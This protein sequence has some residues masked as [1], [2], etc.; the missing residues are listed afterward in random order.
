MAKEEIEKLKEKVEKDPLSK[1]FVPLA[2]EYRKN[3]MYDEAISVLLKGLENQPNYMTARVALGKIYLEKKMLKEAKEEFKKVVTAIPDNLFALKKIADIS[4]ELGE[5]SDAID[6][7]SKI[8]KLNPLDEEAK[9]SLEALKSKK[10]EERIPEPPASK[11]LELTKTEAKTPTVTEPLKEEPEHFELEGFMP[12]SQTSYS[13]EEFEKF[14]N[15]FTS[16]ANTEETSKMPDISLTD[17]A[18]EEPIDQLEEIQELQEIPEEDFFI[19][20]PELESG[21]PE[22]TAPSFTSSQVESILP[23][24]QTISKSS[25]PDFSYP[26][27][28]IQAGNYAKA[29][30]VYKKMLSDYPGDRRIIQRLEELKALLKIL[31]KGN[32][33]VVHQLTNF[34]EAIKKRK[35]EFLG[36]T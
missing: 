17:Y 9:A 7:Y 22:V 11:P 14:K 31:G 36:N 34:L 35:D 27:S 20:T 28:L 4:A 19:E 18:L 33:L 2:E 23:E 1:L 12:I 16:R 21:E 6:A 13:D 3:G 30:E 32:E 15:E 10:S 5:I 8:I 25:A 26:D 24:P 29:I